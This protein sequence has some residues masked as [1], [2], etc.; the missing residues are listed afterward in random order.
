MSLIL[1]IDTSRTE[2]TRVAIVLDGKRF[3]KSSNSRQLK[4]QTVLP[5]VQELLTEH[6]VSFSSVDEI[7]VV[8]GPG[9]FT[10]LRVGIAV[11]NALATLLDIPVNSKRAL[12]NPTY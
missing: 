7:M 4:S 5:L 9:S 8:E 11:A 12:V 1:F 3:E 2:E 6:G 10:G